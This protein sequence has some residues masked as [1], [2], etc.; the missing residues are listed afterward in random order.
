ME[1]GNWY[2]PKANHGDIH[3]FDTLDVDEFRGEPVQSLARETVQNAIDAKLPDPSKPVVVEFSCKDVGIDTIPAVGKVAKQLDNCKEFGKS[4]NN[5]QERLDS[6]QKSICELTTS[7]L[8][9]SD[10]NT[11]GLTDA[12]NNQI[13]GRW[14]G[15]VRSSGIS[16]KQEGNL[17][18]RGIGKFAAFTCSGL[19]MVFYSTLN[20]NQEAAHEGVCRL[21][22]GYADDSPDGDHTQGPGYFASS[23]RNDA[24][25]GQLDNGW[26]KERKSG[27]SGT[28]VVIVG[29]EKPKHWAVHVVSH[30]LDSFLLAVYYGT[31]E[32]NVDGNVVNKKT[33]KKLIENPKL[34]S[35]RTLKSILP[36]YECLVG[37]NVVRK[38]IVID[39]FEGHS[40]LLIKRYEMDEASK[41]S[42]RCVY[43]RYPYMKICEQKGIYDY[44]APFSAILILE[45]G[46]LAD[47]LRKLENSKHTGWEP[48]RLHDESEKE[49]AEQVIDELRKKVAQEILAVLGGGNETETDFS[50]VSEY[51]KD[52]I[53]QPNRKG[54]KGKTSTNGSY[55]GP[56]R[57]RRIALTEGYE[58]K[59]DSLTI[60][61]D[62]EG[63]E[64]D[65]DF[66]GIPSGPT[67]DEVRR[68][69]KAPA[70]DLNVGF[71][72]A[73]TRELLT[74]EKLGHLHWRMML[75]SP[76]KNL[77]A[78][79]IM[80][81]T[82]VKRC[83]VEF[84]KVDDSNSES[85]LEIDSCSCKGRKLKVV[86]NT[87][88]FLA[89]KKNKLIRLIVTTKKAGYLSGRIKLYECRK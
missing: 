59:N 28:D 20:I 63:S 79:T 13:G 16:N 89:V 22:S 88:G 78:F 40:V 62:I 3:G 86:G 32:A 71:P 70:G 14:F 41:A 35:P 24:I 55:L 57:K 81:P 42:R 69:G 83:Q 10:H 84:Y 72:E 9:I 5:V 82:T 6:M 31:L 44:G 66:D 49:R 58:E 75:I 54:L 73:G 68:P 30:I 21:C 2:F 87:A 45:N 65:D 50:G 43:V 47:Y 36:Q 33:L 56:L 38:E 80:I 7:I 17:G 4:L 18:S 64:S 76:E 11:T 26:I 12:F 27:D 29:F 77:W 60:V 25:A 52:K 74:A 61:P 85:P 48:G 23:D 67:G 37:Q 53:P 39:G 51:L 34:I 19:S 15:L 46:P 8:V 1:S